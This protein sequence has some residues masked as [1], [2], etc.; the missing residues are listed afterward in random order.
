MKYIIYIYI[1]DKKH[2]LYPQI[3]KYFDTTLILMIYA[4]ISQQ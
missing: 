3:L 1:L 2:F 4:N